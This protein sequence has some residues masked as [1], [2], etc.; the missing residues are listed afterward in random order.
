MKHRPRKQITYVGFYDSSLNAA[1][2]R[3]FALSAT[4]KMD[5][6]CGVINGIGL[7]VRIVSPAR[8]GNKSTY[9]GKQ[10]QLT[11][12]IILKLFPTF[13]W[14]NLLQK[15]FSMIAGHIFLFLYLAFNTRRD[16]N[17]L[18]YHSLGLMRSV[19]YAKRI[20]GFRVILEVEE[21]YQDV[22]LVQFAARKSEYATFRA[23]DA[24]LFSTGLLDE[25]L[26]VER[27]PHVVVHGAYEVQLDR[28]LSFCDDR[29]HVV[30][31]GIIDQKKG[32]ATVAAS[33]ATYLD[34]KY[35]IHIVGFGDEAEIRRLQQIVA[36]ISLATECDLT[37]DGLLRGD[38]FLEFLQ[39]CDIGLSTQLAEAAFNDTSFPSK[40]LS[41]MANGLAVVS[42]RIRSLEESTVAREIVFY[43]GQ[44]PRDIAEAIRSIRASARVD[45]R[46]LIGQLNADFVEELRVLLAGSVPG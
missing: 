8:T 23:A 29:I 34:A 18:V 4:N 17:V 36:G 20:R 27:K 33:V 1:E 43:D 37:Y 13:P 11:D 44:D 3:N 41:Y 30:Y 21:I 32:G 39:K 2:A 42:V 40:V 31:A 5:Y 26:N 6:I 15:A 9:R 7:D 24:F 14:G 45:S 19:R 46:A 22:G 25:K 10:V 16:E 12:H 38:E 28:G 35:H